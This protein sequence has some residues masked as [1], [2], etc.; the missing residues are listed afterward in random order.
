MGFNKSARKEAKRQQEEALKLQR[1]SF[2]QNKVNSKAYQDSYDTRNAFTIDA[3][4]SASDFLQRYKKGEDISTLDPS[5]SKYAN[6]VADQVTRT[7]KVSNQLGSNAFTK[8]DSG[9]QAKLNSV[10]SRD[11]AKGMAGLANDSLMSSVA[12]NRGLGLQTTA[13]LNADKQAGYGMDTNVF[14]LTNSIFT[15]T[16]AKRKQEDDLG[17]AQMGMLL[18]GLSGAVSGATGISTLFKK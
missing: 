3:R 1:E 7:Y 16:S 9:Y 11:V 14:D 8:G 13:L 4:N 15:N 12:E 6:Q 5:A 17:M 2:E 18:S 10:A